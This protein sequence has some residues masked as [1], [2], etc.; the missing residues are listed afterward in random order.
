[1]HTPLHA[2]VTHAES[3]HAAGDPHCPVAEQVCTPLPEH[4]V[5]PG[6]H[7]PLHPPATHAELTHVTGELH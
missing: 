5:A 1:V 7:T 4:W 3:V 2:P 6:V